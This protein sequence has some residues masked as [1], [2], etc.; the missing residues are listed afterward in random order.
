M[1]R[2]LPGCGALLSVLLIGLAGCA[3]IQ[4]NVLQ[5]PLPTRLLPTAIALTLQAGNTAPVKTEAPAAT[6]TSSPTSNETGIS[7][8]YPQ[9]EGAY[10][11]SIPT[12]LP[13]EPT[14]PPSP[15]T[16]LPSSYPEI[17]PA[18]IE[19]YNL[20]PLSKVVSP[21]HIYASLVPGAENRVTIELLGEDNRLLA[22][23]IKTMYYVRPGK[24]G[25]LWI[26]L[27]FEISATA[28]AG[29]LV[30]SV[31]DEH[32]RTTALNSVPLILMAVGYADIAAPY[33]TLAPIAIL[34]PRA[35]SVIQGGTLL[36]SGYARTASDNP[37]TVRLLTTAGSEVG[38]RLARLDPALPG[39]F[40]AFALEVPYRVSEPGEVLLVVLERDAKFSQIINLSSLEIFLS[41]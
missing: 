32:G 21:I 7:H 15:P 12:I 38:M 27:D 35:N 36:V 1:R 22:R 34:Q 4:N 3:R 14:L 8:A 30:I 23:L 20:G 24:R 10:P 17:P 9:A 33:D 25:I 31:E 19:I 13:L 28:E 39:G 29:R 11:F 40:R 16:T 18:N 41:P 37:L 2:L 6:P 5:T 26:D